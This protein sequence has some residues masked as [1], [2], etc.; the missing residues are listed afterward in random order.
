MVYSPWLRTVFICTNSVLPPKGS[1]STVKYNERT[2]PIQVPSFRCIQLGCSI[3]S[4]S[5]SS[6]FFS[7]RDTFR[8]GYC[9][10][11][12]LKIRFLFPEA[13]LED[14]L[15]VFGQLNSFNEHN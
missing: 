7:R 14:D 8:R 13:E 11:L 5:F 2:G 10:H 4:R 1:K 9:K 3:P 15:F 12:P 6:A